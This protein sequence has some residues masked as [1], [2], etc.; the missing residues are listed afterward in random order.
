[1]KKHNFRDISVSWQ[2]AEVPNNPVNFFK[3]SALSVLENVSIGRN[4]LYKW[5]YS[6][7]KVQY[8]QLPHN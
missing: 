7:Y 4:F 1:M 6:H 2:H 5:I 3:K 8:E